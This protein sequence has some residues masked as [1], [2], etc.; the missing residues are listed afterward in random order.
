MAIQWKSDPKEVE[1][2]SVIHRE[3]R[4]LGMGIHV[5]VKGNHITLSGTA[6]DFETK[7]QIVSVVRGMAGVREI[8]ANIHVAR[9]AD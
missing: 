5:A 7:R 6:D 2:E 4:G 9:I 1:L 3:I 8:T